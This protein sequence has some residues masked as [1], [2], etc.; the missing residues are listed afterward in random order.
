MQATAKEA[1]RSGGLQ[2]E[3]RRLLE[4]KMEKEAE[5]QSLRLS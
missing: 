4:Q 3:N 5:V 1:E 2:Q